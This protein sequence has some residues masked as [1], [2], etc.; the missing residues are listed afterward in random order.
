ML[1]IKGKMWLSVAT[2]R[3]ACFHIVQDKYTAFLESTA[4]VGGKGPTLFEGRKNRTG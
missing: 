3:D 2:W 1:K 4:K